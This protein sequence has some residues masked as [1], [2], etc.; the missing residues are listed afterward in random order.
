MEEIIAYSIINASM[1]F[2]F[3]LN[4]FSK[5][6]AVINKASGI[7]GIKDLPLMY[8]FPFNI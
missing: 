8:S 3:F 7:N 1:L 6:S 4:I 2:L 5:K